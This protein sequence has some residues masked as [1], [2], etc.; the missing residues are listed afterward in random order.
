MVFSKFAQLH[1]YQ[2]TLTLKH[3]YSVINGFPACLWSVST[4]HLWSCIFGFYFF[5]NYK[6]KKKDTNLRMAS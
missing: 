2:H 1:S 6:K 5:D 3:L 4:Y